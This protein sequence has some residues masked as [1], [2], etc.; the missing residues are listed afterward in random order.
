MTQPTTSS[1]LG[2]CS[3]FIMVTMQAM[4]HKRGRMNIYCSFEE[5]KKEDAKERQARSS[6]A[7]RVRAIG[8]H[9]CA[10]RV[11]DDNNM[12]AAQ[13]NYKEKVRKEVEVF[14][15][16]ARVHHFMGTRRAQCC[17]KNS[18]HHAFP[19]NFTDPLSPHD[20]LLPFPLWISSLVPL[21]FPFCALTYT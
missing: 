1:P 3:H 8:R 17:P 7:T 10:A 11:Y 20:P 21:H 18:S 2:T 9:F 19:L 15:A 12:A 14:R 4:Y 16:Y 5:K 13:T 6:E